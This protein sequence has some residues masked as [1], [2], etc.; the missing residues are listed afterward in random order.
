[1]LNETYIGIDICKANLDLAVRP[2]QEQWQKPNDPAGIR[3]VVEQ[4]QQLKPKLIVVEATGGLE[5]ALAG[6][7]QVAQLPVAVV[8]PRQAR[9]FAKATG[10]LAKTDQLDAHNLAHYAQAIK[11]EPRALPD[12]QRQQ[13]SAVLSRRRQVVQMCTAERQRLSSTPEHTRVRLVKHLEW[14]EAELAEL[15]QE[16][17]TLVAQSQE[18]KAQADQLQSTPGVGAVTTFT[19]LAELPELGQLNRKQ[20][21]ALVGVAPLNADSGRYRGRRIVWGG[22]AAV[23][24]VLYMATLAAVRFNPVIKVF[25]DRLSAAGKPKKVALTACMR[26][27]LTILNAM[28]KSGSHW[29]PT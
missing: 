8:N 17:D 10:Q 25:Y 18:W 14:L 27:L 6:A 4:L 5:R 11:P 16:L 7:L 15:D 13:L 20:I 28:L 24:S 19:L 29:N 9:D 21:A 12:Q 26:K 3:Q 1:M 2:S 23:R 22:R